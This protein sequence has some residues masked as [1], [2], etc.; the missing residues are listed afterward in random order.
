MSQS[1]LSRDREDGAIPARLCFCY[2]FE[3]AVGPRSWL[4][5]LFL[6]TEMSV[7]VLFLHDCCL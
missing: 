1:S 2:K 3:L 7:R 4:S 5:Q 6:W